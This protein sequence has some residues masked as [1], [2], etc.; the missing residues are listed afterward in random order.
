MS[1][2]REGKV[3]LTNSWGEDL[4]SVRVRHRRSNSREKEEHKLINN[5][6]KDAKNIFIM[7]ITYDVSFWA[8]D[9]DYWWILFNTNDWRTYT[10]KNNFWCNIT[11]SDDGNVSMLINGHL[12][13]MSVDFSQ[14]NLDLTSIYEIY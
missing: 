10:V 9:F 13:H 7:D 1:D 14:S 11:P 6:S 12:M 4:Q 5:V 2:I 3:F 8:P